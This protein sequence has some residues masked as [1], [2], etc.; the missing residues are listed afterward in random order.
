MCVYQN[1]VTVDEL[2]MMRI[3]QQWVINKRDVTLILPLYPSN[4]ESTMGRAVR[5]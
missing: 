4:T 2:M 5:L 1:N 3:L